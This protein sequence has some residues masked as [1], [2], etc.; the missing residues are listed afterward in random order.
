MTRMMAHNRP[1]TVPPIIAK[2]ETNTM[3]TILKINACKY[4]Q[5]FQ[6][7]QRKGDMTVLLVLVNLDT[8]L[9]NFQKDLPIPENMVQDQNLK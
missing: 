3:S 8:S 7:D 1:T 6:D 2:D 9:L 4:L 5:A